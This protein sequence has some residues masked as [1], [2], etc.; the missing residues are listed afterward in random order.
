MKLLAAR[1]AEPHKDTR[2]EMKG[3]WNAGPWIAH[4]VDT[5]ALRIKSS[6]V[7]GLGAVWKIL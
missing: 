6:R 1:S 3:G 5:A 7:H 2:S 4:V